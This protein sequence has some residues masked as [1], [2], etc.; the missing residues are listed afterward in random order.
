MQNTYEIIKDETELKK[1]ID[2]LPELKDGEKFMVALFARNKFGKTPGLTADKA[3][4]KRFTSN[5]YDLI[6]KL[7]QL[8]VKIGAYTTGDITINQESLVV[9]ITPNP[10]DMH[11]SGLKTILE[12]TKFMVEG[13]TIFNPQ[14][15]ALNMIQVTSTK[16]IYF[17]LDI[18]IQP[19]KLFS[20]EDL[21]L[22]LVDKIN[23]DAI[24]SIIK[25]RGGFHI[26]INLHEISKEFSSKWFNNFANGKNEFI[27]VTMNGDNMIPMPGCVQSE[28]SPIML[29]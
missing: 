2:F 28:S 8:E 27:D 18:D 3:Q 25:T 21:K 20:E 29:T 4:L 23:A 1:F 14:S 24:G 6:R 22:W 7:K 17:D 19:N 12:L 26:L 15:V 16:K 13:R 9:Y 10:R 11:K 5:K